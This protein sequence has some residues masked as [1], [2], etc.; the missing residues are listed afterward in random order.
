MKSVDRT[1][2]NPFVIPLLTPVQPGNYGNRLVTIDGPPIARQIQQ[3][4]AAS[5]SGLPTHRFMVSIVEE[6]KPQHVLAIHLKQRLSDF[7]AYTL[8]GLY[9]PE[10][11]PDGGLKPLMEALA[12]IANNSH[13]PEE[14]LFLLLT[15]DLKQCYQLCEDDPILTTFSAAFKALKSRGG[16]INTNEYFLLAGKAIETALSDRD[17]CIDEIYKYALTQI[18]SHYLEAQMSVTIPEDLQNMINELDLA[19]PENVKANVGWQ[20]VI[21]GLFDSMFTTP[22]I[23]TLHLIYWLYTALQS[24]ETGDVDNNFSFEAQFALVF[25]TFT[26]IKMAVESTGNTKAT[27]QLIDLTTNTEKDRD[28]TV[29]E[30]LKGCGTNVTKDVSSIA[31]TV[32]AIIQANKLI[33]GFQALNAVVSSFFADSVRQRV[34]DSAGVSCNHHWLSPAKFLTGVGVAATLALSIGP[35][36]QPSLFETL[37]SYP[38]DQR[39]GFIEST[40]RSIVAS[41][42][43][44]QSDYFDEANRQV[45]LMAQCISAVVT[46]LTV[47]SIVRCSDPTMR[48][49]LLKNLPIFLF[50]ASITHLTALFSMASPYKLPTGQTVG[51]IFVASASL[52][53]LKAVVW[54][55]CVAKK[56]HKMERKALQKAR[57]KVLAAITSDIKQQSSTSDLRTMKGNLNVIEQAIMKNG[58]SDIATKINAIQRELTPGLLGLLDSM[59]GNQPLPRTITFHNTQEAPNSTHISRLFDTDNRQSSNGNSDA[60]INSDAKNLDNLSNLRETKV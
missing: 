50:R 3:E 44:F 40:F 15:E 11:N 45:M 31:G 4:P 5:S 8:G 26:A 1:S 17:H 58:G 56:N 13:D 2:E 37:F 42:G 36:L 53:F 24:N 46:V 14:H 60:T 55:D 9:D 27:K 32:C 33:P 7:S 16:S 38:E 25:A 20:R 30:L 19:L 47:E 10:Q 57:R 29:L 28:A 39:L 43:T 12:T 6:P 18:V 34:M 41:L 21:A 51:A 23:V 49:K 52:D 59:P 22:S 48:C 35:L 54:E